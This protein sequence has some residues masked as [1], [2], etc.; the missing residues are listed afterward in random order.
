MAH[1]L[2]VTSSYFPENTVPAIR[3][4]ETARRLLVRGYQVT[5]LTIIPRFPKGQNGVV[6]RGRPLQVEIVGG[7]RII[8][9]WSYAV[10]EDS[11]RRR[12]L[13]QYSSGYLAPLLSEKALGN[14][15]LILVE[16]LPLFN[17]VAARKLAIRKRCPFV[18]IAADLW[19]ESTLLP[20]KVQ[21]IFVRHWV[22]QA[23]RSTYQKAAAIWALSSGVRETLQ[24]RGVPAERVFVLPHGVDTERFSPL[25]RSVA[26]A[27]LGWP[28]CF[29]LLY[30]GA[31][32]SIQGLETLLEAAARLEKYTDIRLMLVGE[33]SAKESLTRHA[34][35]HKLT[36]V[37]FLSEQPHDLMPVL[38]SASDL[39]LVPLRREEHYE[40]VLP[41]KMFEMMACARPIV[42]GIDGEAR[43]VAEREAEAAMF[44]EPESTSALVDAIL[45]LRRY[46]EIAHVMG[47]RGRTF[48][49][50]YWNSDILTNK[51]QDHIA[52]ILESGG[53][54]PIFR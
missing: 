5:V 40:G 35:E 1:I 13:A 26:R 37:T 53:K 6:Y 47:L 3:V 50:N 29:T 9:V 7:V 11:V 23:G 12:L 34:R 2:F 44:V 19:P 48:V 21:D 52:Q 41:V 24:Q 25:S 22:E 20:E 33:G 8:R 36:N 28:E 10:P 49:E 43:L 46:P 18:L 42:L 16:A 30:V 51:L 31:H 45:Y 15:D 27:S 38:I 39:C 4:Y 17:A 14:P 54:T 32:G